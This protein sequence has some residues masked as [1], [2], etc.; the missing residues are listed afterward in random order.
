MHMHMHMHM[1]CMCMCMQKSSRDKM[2][3]VARLVPVPPTSGTLRSD[4]KGT[5]V[6][7]LLVTG[8][9]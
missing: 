9:L 6:A 8:F 4:A 2:S 5:N 1:M 3:K 7:R